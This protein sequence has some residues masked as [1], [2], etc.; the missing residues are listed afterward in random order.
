MKKPLKKIAKKIVKTINYKT[1]PA[2]WLEQFLRIR[3]NCYIS[4]GG[5]GMMGS[6]SSESVMK[7]VIYVVGVLKTFMILPHMGYEEF[8][9]FCRK[10]D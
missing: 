3:V 2:I 8:T 10:N 4:Y 1:A 9:V 5:C 6:L 7:R